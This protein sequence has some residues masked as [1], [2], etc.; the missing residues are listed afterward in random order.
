VFLFRQMARELLI[1]RGYLLVLRRPSPKRAAAGCTSTSA[2][3]SIRAATPL[4]TM[5][6]TGT[7]QA[8]GGLHRRPV[9][10][11]R[12]AGGDHG[13]ADQQLCAAA[14]GQ[15]FGLLGELGH[16][17]PLGHGARFGG[18][19]RGGADR[20][21][22][23]RLRGQPY[24]ALAAL[25]AALLGY[26]KGYELPARETNDGLETTVTDRHTPHSLPEALDALEADTVLTETLGT[27]LVANFIAIKRQEVLELEGKSEAE[28]IAYLHFI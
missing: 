24:F 6:P 21:S 5:S 27:E 19:R 7:F 22:P 1:R 2:S 12:G 17:S 9:A 16:R 28:Q 14:T 26:E 25:Q 11:P 23:G 4:P 8:D 3:P 20:A 10:A 13:A 15:P 18:N